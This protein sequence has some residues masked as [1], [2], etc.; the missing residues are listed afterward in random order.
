MSRPNTTLISS[1]RIAD[2]KDKTKY[3]PIIQVSRI[4]KKEDETKTALKNKQDKLITPIEILANHDKS[5]TMKN[6]NKI[7]LTKKINEPVKK[8][9]QPPEIKKGQQKIEWDVR[10]KL[11][12]SKHSPIENNN[13]PTENDAA[14]EEKNARKDYFGEILYAKILAKFNLSG[15]ER[16]VSKVAGMLLE[17]PDEFLNKMVADKTFLDEQTQAAYRLLVKAESNSENIKDPKKLVPIIK[18]EPIIKKATK[19]A[20]IKKELNIKAQNKNNDARPTSLNFI[21][22]KNYEEPFKMKKNKGI[23]NLGS[24]CWINVI[25][26]LVFSIQETKVAIKKYNG[27]DLTIGYLKNVFLELEDC[28]GPSISNKAFSSAENGMAFGLNINEMQDIFLG[29]EYIME[30]LKSTPLQKGIL[31]FDLERVT[32]YK[33]TSYY[34][35]ANTKTLYAILYPNDGNDIIEMMT[36]IQ[37]ESNIECEDCNN[38]NFGKTGTTKLNIKGVASSIIFQIAR[39]AEGNNKKNLKQIS[40]P[41]LI[42]VDENSFMLKAIGMHIGNRPDSGHYTINLR[43]DNKW[44]NFNDDNVKNITIEDALKEKTNVYML[45]YE[46]MSNHSNVITES[47]NPRNIHVVDDI[48]EH[49]TEKNDLPDSVKIYSFEDIKKDFVIKPNKGEDDCGILALCDSANLQNTFTLEVRELIVDN[50]PDAS[51][52]IVD[53]KKYKDDMKKE[54]ALF[55]DLELLAF[56]EM[57]N[58]TLVIFD[59]QEIH[60]IK[61]QINPNKQYKL[62]LIRTNNKNEI[63]HLEG[64]IPKNKEFYVNSKARQAALDNINNKIREKYTTT[65]T[66][67]DAEDKMLDEA[68]ENN[69]NSGSDEEVNPEPEKVIK[70]TK[71]VKPVPIIKKKKAREKSFKNKNDDNSL[72]GDMNNRKNTKKLED[73]PIPHDIR[74][75]VSGMLLNPTAVA[76]K[77]KD[78]LD[79]EK[80][81]DFDEKMLAESQ[82]ISDLIKKMKKEQIFDQPKNIIWDLECPKGEFGKITGLSD[83]ESS[84]LAPVLDLECSGRN[85]AGK[86]VYKLFQ[87]M[88]HYKDHCRINHVTTSRAI[89]NFTK[90]KGYQIIFTEQG[91][92]KQHFLM[93]TEDIPLQ[94]LNKVGKV[95]N[96]DDTADNTEI[97]GRMSWIGWNCRTASAKMNHTLIENY[98]ENNPDIVGISLNESGKIKDKKTKFGTGYS[99]KTS[100]SKTAL[101]HKNEH[102]MTPMLPEM[103]DE[104]NQI[105]RMRTEKGHIIIFNTY[106]QPDERKNA[107]IDAFI[108]RAKTIAHKYVNPSVLIFGDFN[109]GIADFKKKIEDKLKL[110]NYKC[111]YSKAEG[112]FTRIRK[113]LN[114][115]EHSYLDYMI[116][117]NLEDTEM[118]IIK[119]PGHSDHLAI[120]MVFSNYSTGPP[121]IRKELSINYGKIK[122]DAEKIKDDLKSVFEMKGSLA[123]NLTNFIKLQARIYKKRV[124][125]Q[126]NEFFIHNKIKNYLESSKKIDY[127][128]LKKMINRCSQDSYGLFLAQFEKLKTERKVKEYY[129]KLRFYSDLNKRTEII[130]DIMVD[131]IDGP[132]ISQDTYEI[133]KKLLKKYQQVFEDFGKKNIL[134]HGPAS[135]VFTE[136][137][138]KSALDLIN[139]NKATGP[140]LIP[141]AALKLLIAEPETAGKL[142]NL[143]NELFSSRHQIPSELIKSR[144][145]CLNKEPDQVGSE[146]AVRPLSIDSIIAKLIDRVLLT[147]IDKIN[148][149]TPLLH[150]EQ[151]GFVS[152]LGADIGIMLLRDS[153]GRLKLVNKTT[154]KFAVFVDYKMAFDRVPHDRLIKCLNEL[155]IEKGLVEAIAKVYSASSTQI[156]G[157]TVF[158]NRGVRQGSY[159]SPMLFNLYI[160]SLVTLMKDYVFE[161]ILYADDVVFLCDTEEE[162]EV[163]LEK[164]Q[165]WSS[166]AGFEINK[167]K[168]G[169]MSIHNTKKRNGS[170]L[171]GFPLKQHYKYLGLYLDANLHPTQ[172]IEETNRN[173]K[174]Y[175]SRNAWLLKK[176]FTC[177]SLINIYHY[178]QE[179]RVI[180][181][182]CS[183]LDNGP[184]IDKAQKWAMKYLR[185]LLGLKDN[186]ST[187]RTRLAFN[188]TKFEYKLLPRLVK[189]IKKFQNHFGYTPSIYDKTL[190]VY[191]KDMGEKIL[192]LDHRQLKKDAE[193]RSQQLTANKEGIIVGPRFN[194]V[195]EKHLYKY[196]NKMDAFLVRYILKYGFYCERINPQCLHCKEQNSRTHVTN[197]CE[198]FKLSRQKTMEFIGNTIGVKNLHLNDQDLESWIMTIYFN[199][200]IAWTKVQLKKLLDIIKLHIADMYID[201]TKKIKCKEETWVSDQDD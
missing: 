110:F 136:E 12:P 169:I 21:K 154:E 177:K 153:A 124:K 15:K 65:A 112:A 113:T 31:E 174:D 108:L 155:K 88:Y 138:I 178:Y 176:H 89:V 185:S 82:L 157:E 39:F 52:I 93:K 3:H 6:S 68:P 86:T 62:F 22:N 145:V 128:Y 162:L 189:N 172:S 197:D 80:R 115:I 17:L 116:T 64:L 87:S 41:E 173:L 126:R 29:L 160:K 106:I 16:Y 109:L 199:P 81:V 195:I 28:R 122:E 151:I 36:K 50:I 95:D 98:L 97:T 117:L 67:I 1:A 102:T 142:T 190:E 179:S 135:I 103:N 152:G 99:A 137:E 37:E 130:K 90:P 187:R 175:L 181:G 96:E 118:E 10:Q 44:R 7:N 45:V 79:I 164:L 143:L 107:N 91:G 57:M 61:I 11:N 156:G 32:N 129:S 191:E 194:E 20:V 147:R 26:Q 35:T 73:N 163:A 94:F 192:L 198:Y 25:I 42:L 123:S 183:Y 182:L 2:N 100:G 148:S 48:I 193:K 47:T 19:P 23:Q 38:D 134:H 51:I 92:I 75:Q 111:H 127:V 165:E 101:I 74:I 58:C 158:I 9:T 139:T 49:E 119:P 71:E 24:S 125:K 14:P 5:V 13:A 114:G 105:Y 4:L 76:Y 186:V 166:S 54:K 77:N 168:S 146:E 18:T 171:F 161:I 8:N 149:I 131:G 121:T 69:H 170:T 132:E 27:K 53:A 200:S 196:P 72:M 180:Y 78:M 167:K 63:R 56:A 133:N 40:Y 59:Q 33:D 34:N 188:L 85:Q 159:I 84:R 150:K 141:G 43:D 184:L 70:I 140:D 30:T 60:F 83:S 144:M 66:N 104:L 55:S 46:K 120:K 201:Q